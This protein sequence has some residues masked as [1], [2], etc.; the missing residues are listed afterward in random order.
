VGESRARLVQLRHGLDSPWVGGASPTLGLVSRCRSWPVLARRWPTAS[1]P[2]VWR[3][4]RS[5]RALVQTLE[6]RRNSA[7]DSLPDIQKAKVLCAKSS[8]R[9]GAFLLSMG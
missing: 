2:L 5:P 7:R 6:T 8:A 1:A 3:R 4:N 9:A